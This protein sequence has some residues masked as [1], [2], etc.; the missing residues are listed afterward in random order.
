MLTT[1]AQ[2]SIHAKLYPLSPNDASFRNT[3]NS[4]ILDGSCATEKIIHP[5]SQEG[6]R[7]LIRSNEELLYVTT[8]L[9]RKMLL[10]NDILSHQLLFRFLNSALLEFGT[11]T[12][13]ITSPR[14]RTLHSVIARKCTPV[15]VKMAEKRDEAR[16]STS[17]SMLGRTVTSSLMMESKPGD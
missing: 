8:S 3:A 2:V 16:S 1:D 10:I 13:P 11:S 5:A 15:V 12:G 9:Y 6:I 14:F 7:P 17:A 4:R